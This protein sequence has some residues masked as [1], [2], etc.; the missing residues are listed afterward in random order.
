[1]DD[2]HHLPFPKAVELFIGSAQVRKHGQFV[3]SLVEQHRVMGSHELIAVA[4][5]QDAPRLSRINRQT[6]SESSSRDQNTRDRNRQ[7]RQHR[8]TRATHRP[9]L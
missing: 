3:A 7:T 8:P 6:T 1:L 2:E 4:A 9:L 5:D